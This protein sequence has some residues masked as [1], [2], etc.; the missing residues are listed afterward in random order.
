MEAPDEIAGSSRLLALPDD[1]QRVIFSLLSALRPAVVLNLSAC[2][3]ELRA[4]SE[5]ARAELRRQHSAATRLCARANTTIHEV[6]GST[7]LLWYGQGLTV[8]HLATLGRCLSTSA[9]SH[10]EQLNL[11]VNR[12][13]A[14]GAIALFG[15]L[16]RGSLPRL[17]VL[18][19]TGNVM[20]A[21]GAAALAAALG[22][23]A[24]PRLEIL[25]L[26]RNAIGDAGLVALALPLRRL[27]A[28]REVYLHG[29]QIGDAGVEALLS[30]L[31]R[32]SSSSACRRSTSSA[33]KSTTPAAPRSPRS[34]APRGRTASPRRRRSRPSKS[35]T[36]HAAR[37]TRGDAGVGGKGFG[38][39]SLTD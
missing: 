36:A 5:A 15:A 25:T 31:G 9:L 39:G 38:V 11:S 4:V 13:G 29:N 28:L 7:D 12:F 32:E 18:D 30:N 20:G 21:A 8:Q 3:A 17:T 33:T 1:G 26:G 27:P 23:G 37:P 19:L 34:A 22:R 6:L 10:L 35:R 16:G 14:E 2:C 24:L